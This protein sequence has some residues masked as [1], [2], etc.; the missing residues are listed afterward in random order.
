MTAGI[1]SMTF[2]F[3]KL[4]FKLGWREKNKHMSIAKSAKGHRGNMK[5]LWK[6]DG[7]RCRYLGVS[8]NDL[9]MKKTIFEQN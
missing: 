9:F 6:F 3:K 2:P 5:V 4:T 8:R 7:L 1:I